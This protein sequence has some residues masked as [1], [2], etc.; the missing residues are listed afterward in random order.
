MH[1]ESK[2]QFIFDKE[3]TSI[4]KFERLS[5]ERL[6]LMVREEMH[7]WEYQ[8]TMPI[9]FIC[10]LKDRE[11]IEAMTGRT[12]LIYDACIRSLN[13]PVPEDDRFSKLN[14]RKLYERLSMAVL[15][16]AKK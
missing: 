16:H 12:N 4:F 5:V 7:H 9:P 6:R 3:L 2:R 13:R 14:L 8:F 11:E 10:A 15:N 1:D